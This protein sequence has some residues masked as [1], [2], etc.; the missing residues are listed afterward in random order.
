MLIPV[1][2]MPSALNK[3]RCRVAREIIARRFTDEKIDRHDMVVSFKEHGL[4]QDEI[5]DESL[6]QL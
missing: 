4:S 3:P 1:S 2:G 5:A 6:F